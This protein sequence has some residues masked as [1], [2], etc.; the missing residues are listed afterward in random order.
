MA[1][2]PEEVTEMRGE[3]AAL[4][5]EHLWLGKTPPRS[6][7]RRPWTMGRELSIWNLLV[8]AHFRPC[9]IN[10]AITVARKLRRDWEG[11]PVRM[12]VFYWQRQGG[13][14]T[15]TPFLEQCIGYHLSHIDRR[16]SKKLAIP[17][18]VGEVL[19]RAIG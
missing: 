18:T 1:I 19:R 16:E 3:A 2:T 13:V 15:A 7:D 6:V 9:D 17:P 12:T 5:R 8:A 10:G 11:T 14:F 4:I